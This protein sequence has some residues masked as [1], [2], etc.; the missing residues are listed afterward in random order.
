MKL[1]KKTGSLL[2]QLS[3][4][5]LRFYRE[6]AR[7]VGDAKVATAITAMI[8]RARVVKMKKG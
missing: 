1:G 5:D 2:P 6:K 3:V 7:E 4:E 8:R